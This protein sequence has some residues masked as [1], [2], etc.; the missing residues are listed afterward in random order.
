MKQFFVFCLVLLSFQCRQHCEKN[1]VIYQGLYFQTGQKFELKINDDVIA[2]EKFEDG[3]QSN[4]LTI[5]DDYCCNSDSCKVDFIL[6]E[7]DTSFYIYPSR[8]KR[9]MVGSDING[10]FSVATD[11]EKRM[12]MD[13]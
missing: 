12:W 8:T 3:Y 4:E 13:M 6:G 11:E 7:A 2:S 5:I 1:V 9:L 10:K